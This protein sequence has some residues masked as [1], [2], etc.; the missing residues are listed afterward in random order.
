MAAYQNPYEDRF[1]PFNVGN[2]LLTIELC[3][4]ERTRIEENTRMPEDVK[5]EKLQAIDEILKSSTVC[6]Q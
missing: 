2:M 6:W 3:L 5:T 4:Q 1:D